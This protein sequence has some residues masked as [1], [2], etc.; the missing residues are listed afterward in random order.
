MKVLVTGAAGFVGYHVSA[1]LLARGDAVIGVDDLNPY[2]D[3]ALKETRLT[4]LTADDGFTFRKLDIAER[5]ALAAACS[6]AGIARVVHLAAQAGVRH[7]L[8]D[9]F[10][11]ARINVVGHL[12]V[13][14]LCRRLDG[15]EHLVYASSSSVYGGNDKQPFAE[16]DRVDCQVSLYGATKKADE[17]MSHSYGHLFGVPATGIRL[18]TVYGPW[19]RPDMAAYIFTR[20]IFAGAPIS[21]F[22]RGDMRR[23]FTYIDDAVGGIVA[24]LD[25]PPPANAAGVRHRIYNIGNDRAEALMDFIAALEA[26]IGR[27]AVIELAPMQPGDVKETIADIAAARRDLGFAPATPIAEGLPRFVAWY[28]DYHGV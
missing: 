26:A 7:S 28:R 15:L 14:E 19:G 17:L 10:A 8:D 1:A 9:P 22:N 25:K 16:T 24:A 18:F 20:S 12:E 6:G 27:K 5:G 11:Y 13:L 21:V 3:V 23:A 4:R 2:Y